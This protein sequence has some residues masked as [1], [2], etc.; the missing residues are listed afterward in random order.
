MTYQRKEKTLY[1]KAKQKKMQKLKRWVEKNT[2]RK[3]GKQQNRG[4]REN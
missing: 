1:E 3:K 2:K 4:S